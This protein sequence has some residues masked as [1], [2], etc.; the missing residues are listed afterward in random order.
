M[1]FK[2]NIIL[3]VLWLFVSCSEDESMILDEC[4]SIAGMTVISQSEAKN[5]C[6]YNLVYRYQSEIYTTCIC[7]NCFKAHM[8]FDCNGDRLCETRDC[9]DDFDRDAQFLFFAIEG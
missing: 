7:C 5:T 6:S 1:K 4:N 3:L 9:M 8:A 2:F